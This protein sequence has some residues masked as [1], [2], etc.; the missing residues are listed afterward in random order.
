MRVDTVPHLARRRHEGA[1]RLGRVCVSRVRREHG[2]NEPLFG[3]VY[4]Q[5]E[6]A[7][8]RDLCQRVGDARGK[9]VVSGAPPDGEEP[10]R[11]RH[12]AAGEATHMPAPRDAHVALRLLEAETHL[13]VRRAPRAQQLGDVVR[14]DI[15]EQ[16]VGELLHQFDGA[17]IRPPLLDEPA[18]GAATRRV[19][20]S[21]NEPRQQQ[22]PRRVDARG[23]T[24]NAPLAHLHDVVATH[25]HRAVAHQHRRPVTPHQR[26]RRVDDVVAGARQARAGRLR[27]PG[28]GDGRDAEE[29]EGAHRAARDCFAAGE[30]GVVAG[31]HTR[32]G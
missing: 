20:V 2:A 27:R 14:R 32:V 10:R 30:V 17:L 31:S 7:V 8:G 3:A 5:G 18:R 22:L 24:A 1:H 26:R 19:R 23:R 4:L 9:R 15:V 11:A 13:H 25:A 29:R 12:H 21:R 6:R 28:I 16:V